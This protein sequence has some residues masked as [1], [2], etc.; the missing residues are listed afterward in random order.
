M[1]PDRRAFNRMLSLGGVALLGRPP[2]P[3]AEALPPTPAEPD[4]AF[5]ARVKAQFAL[6]AGIAH[7][8]AANLCPSPRPVLEAMHNASDLDHDLSPRNR[9][10]MHQAKEEARA[11]L[12]RL[13]RVSPEEVV[14]VRNTSEGNNLVS[15]GLDL[16]PG[17]EV[18]V[19]AD[20]H[21]SNLAA[22]HEKARRF[23]YA[24][25]T[26]P[27]AP[28]HPG[29]EA[30]V[31]AFAERISPRTRLVAFTHL[32]NTVGDLWP[33]AELCRLARERGALS[34][35]DGAQAFGLMDLD[36]RALGADFYTGSA[37]K[38]LCGPKETGLLY[39]RRDAQDRLRPSIVSL[40]PGAVGLSRSFEGFGQRDEP[41]FAGLAAAAAFVS[42][43]GLAAIEARAKALA[44]MLIAGLDRLPGVRLWT[45]PDPARSH[46]VVSFEP[47][48]LDPERLRAALFDEV[49]VIAAVRTGP[50]RP[51]LR[52]SPH[53]Y[54]LTAEIDTTLAVLERHLRGGAAARR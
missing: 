9:E 4:E 46:A 14:L 2:W 7:L 33:V 53:L 40:Y 51:G 5:W 28:S 35:V 36:L 42:G 1:T 27:A 17:D 52:L 50:D 32:T 38:W 22:W 13:L 23:G 47:G 43:I 37:H 31:A 54:N 21:A 45:H 25:A 16:G 3:R 11:A 30:C 44:R 15:S 24:V 20:N 26:V 34:L 39:V 41:A 29:P 12:A 48:G 8:N 10:R 19:F 18:V 6:P 49:G